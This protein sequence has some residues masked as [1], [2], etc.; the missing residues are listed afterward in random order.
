MSKFR[1]QEPSRGAARIEE[2]ELRVPN[3]RNRSE[4]GREGD[5][6]PPAGP[7]RPSEVRVIAPSEAGRI[8]L[9]YGVTYLAS[10]VR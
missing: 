9:G 1:D 4:Y 8:G 7:R 3:E 2:L 10:S 6:R 5:Q